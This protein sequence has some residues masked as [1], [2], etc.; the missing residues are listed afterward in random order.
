MSGG[1][2]GL[3]SP[4]PTKPSPLCLSP[5]AS[6]TTRQHAALPPPIAPKGLGFVYAVTKNKAVEAAANAVY[7]V[8]AKYRTEL[9]GREALGVILQRR[10]AEAAGRGDDGSLCGDDATECEVPLKK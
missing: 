9:T 4:T 3:N 2:G 7:E 8:W 5:P 10:A 6:A 1:G